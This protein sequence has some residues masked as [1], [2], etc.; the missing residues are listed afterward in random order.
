MKM[1]KKISIKIYAVLCIV[2]FIQHG[3]ASDNEKP[4]RSYIE[5]VTHPTTLFFTSIVTL[6]GYCWYDPALKSQTYEWSKQQFEWV[7]QQFDALH[8]DA[9]WATAGFG[10]LGLYSYWF[11][12]SKAREEKRA[13]ENFKRDYKKFEELNA[14]HQALK[15][16]FEVTRSDY[17]SVKTIF[18]A[19]IRFLEQKDKGNDENRGFL[20]E[21][22]L[23]IQTDLQ[24]LQ[25]KD[26]ENA[27]LKG[28]V[29]DVIAELQNKIKRL[30]TNHSELDSSDDEGSGSI[31]IKKM[32]EDDERVQSVV[33]RTEYDKPN[34]QPF[35]TETIVDL[36][37]RISNLEILVLGY[38]PRSV[39]P[40]EECRAS[41]IDQLSEGLKQAHDW[42]E[43]LGISNDTHTEDLTEMDNRLT[44]IEKK[45]IALQELLADSY[46]S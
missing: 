39:G 30:E 35:P 45:S 33:I 36:A 16:N 1:L 22:L 24:S 14:S 18:G 11:N 26:K 15:N 32:P 13:H 46:A 40:D 34:M 44:L 43:Q 12:K 7:K 37:S 31:V 27:A 42:M 2:F 17:G 19:R 20:D 21:A 5:Y 6:G 10:F 3:I 38:N 8:P 9:K 29:F 41:K 23:G 25:D 4:K 28:K